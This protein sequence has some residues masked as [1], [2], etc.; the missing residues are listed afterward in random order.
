MQRTPL[1]IQLSLAAIA[2]L[3]TLAGT[4]SAETVY[5]VTDLGSISPETGSNGMAVNDVRQIVGQAAADQYSAMLHAFFWQDGVMTDLQTLGGHLQSSATGI[6]SIGQVTGISFDLGSLHPQA[7]LWQGSTLIPIGSFTPNAINN[8]GHVAGTQDTLQL[9]GIWES[10]AVMW[11]GSTII[12]LGTLGGDNSYAHDIN[13]NDAVVGVSQLP[14]GTTT[15]AFYSAT[16]TMNDLGTLGGSRSHA[17]AINDQ[18]H[19]VGV[20]DNNA[21]MPHAFL[22]HL[23]AQG[24]VQQRTDLGELGG[25]NSYA[26]DINEQDVVVGTSDGSAF[27]W[28]NNVMKDLNQL[29]PVN[30]GWRLD[31]ARSVSN[32]GL[33]TGYGKH[34]GVQRAFLLTPAVILTNRNL[35]SVV[36]PSNGDA[37]SSK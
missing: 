8:A 12:S 20:A 17:Y 35:S 5:F 2:V 24:Q 31:A 30:S 22:F 6:N 7:F 14:D 10:Q 18:R 4:L 34:L 11:N 3:L 23:N 13:N 26:F 25:G 29:I 1:K 9:N 21:G 19:V 36:G 33:I 28:K 15:H 27:V 32:S 16:G 37:V